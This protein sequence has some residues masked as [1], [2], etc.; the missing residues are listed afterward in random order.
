VAR[1]FRDDACAMDALVTHRL[2][3]QSQRWAARL[4]VSPRALMNR[5]HMETSVGMEVEGLVVHLWHDVYGQRAEQTVTYPATWWDAFKTRFFPAWALKRWPAQHASVTV[6]AH[7][8]FPEL[9]GV[10][11]HQMIVYRAG[12]E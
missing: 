7:A 1:L 12:F 9:E 11:R 10:G 8:L 4:H 2:E 3:L 6:Q 5:T